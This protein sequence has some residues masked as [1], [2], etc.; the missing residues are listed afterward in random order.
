MTEMILSLDD[1]LKV[2]GTGAYLITTD[3]RTPHTSRV[4]VTPHKE[5]LS[6]EI[7]KTAARNA[8]NQAAASL[9]W[10]PVEKTGYDLIVNGTVELLPGHNQGATKALLRLSKAVLHQPGQATDP[11]S[12]C[13]ADC[14]PLRF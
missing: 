7:G 11:E 1:A 13:A 9:L 5:G 2:Y 3:A 4:N 10:P 8:C 6:F 12:S 14:E